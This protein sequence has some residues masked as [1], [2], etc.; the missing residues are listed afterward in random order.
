MKISNYRPDID[1]LRGLSI[2]S[3][4]IYHLDKSLI[5]GGFL[6]VDIFFVI[7]GFLI[8]K[9]LISQLQENKFSF[10][11]FYL[12]RARRLFPNLF[13]MLLITSCL[14]TFFLLPYELENF[15]RSVY[16]ALTFISNIFFWT[17]LNYFD[18]DSLKFPLLHTWSLGIEEQFYLFFPLFLFCFFRL[19]NLYLLIFILFLISLFLAE[20]FSFYGP[21]G[22]FY[23]II[24]RAWE[25]LA[26]FIS[27]FLQERRNR[28]F[29][30]LLFLT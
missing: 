30:H 1:G 26:G 23:L 16:F 17:E 14:F 12:N 10:Q 19:K 28:F 7:S 8:S 3:V 24:T 13:L 2:L 22:N 20:Y 15:S 9:I 18:S 6:G 25:L 27:A 21:Q 29:N 4:F 5:P 11:V